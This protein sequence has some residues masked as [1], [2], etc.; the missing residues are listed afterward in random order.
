MANL[1]V[2]LPAPAANGSGAWV[3]CSGLGPYRTITASSILGTVTI[4]FSNEAVAANATPV[5]SFTTGGQTTVPLVARWM[6]ATVSGYRGGGVPNVDVG[7]SDTGG[8][9]ANLAAPADSGSGV[10]T[11]TSALGTMKTVQV[12]GSFRGGVTI[13]ITEDNVTWE[14]VA[15]FQN[16]GQYTAMFTA[17]FMRVTRVNVPIVSPGLPVV[18]VGGSDIGGGGG[19]GG[20]DRQSFSYTV[21]GAEPDRSLITVPLPAARASTNYVVMCTPGG[22]VDIVGYDCPA[23]SYALGQFVLALTIAAQIGD[24]FNFTVEDKT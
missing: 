21:T 2:N 9:F 22:L 18:N 17:Q 19:G 1:F 14:P 4:E 10:A 11:D 13:E 8:T 5:V 24:V 16:P 7:A 20:G 6:R 15:A 23:S 3:D 12:A